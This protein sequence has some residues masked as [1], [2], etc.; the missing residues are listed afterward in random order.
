MLELQYAFR[1]LPYLDVTGRSRLTIQLTRITL[2]LPVTLE[3]AIQDAQ[4]DM[5]ADGRRSTTDD[6]GG[7]RDKA[8][9]LPKHVVLLIRGIDVILDKMERI[10]G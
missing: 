7:E 8:A 2:S 5:F 1:R 9:L 6:K 10:L 3:K 4:E